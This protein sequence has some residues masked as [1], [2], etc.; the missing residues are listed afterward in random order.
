MMEFLCSI[1]F[2]LKRKL[3]FSQ[4]F[5]TCPFVN[6]TVLVS[7]AQNYQKSFV[8]KLWNLKKAI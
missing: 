3:Y 6:W 7:F 2:V 5:L 4:S 8:L 1:N